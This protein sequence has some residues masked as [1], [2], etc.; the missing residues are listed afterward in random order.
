[1][2]RSDIIASKVEHL[3]KAAS[4]RSVICNKRVVSFYAKTDRHKPPHTYT[5]KYITGL[6][7]AKDLVIQVIYSTICKY[8]SYL[9]LLTR[10]IKWIS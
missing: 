6:A 10:I 5:P 7:T 9:D 3:V 4:Q 2:C 8:T 1:M